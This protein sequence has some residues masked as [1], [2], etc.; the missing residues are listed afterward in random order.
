MASTSEARVHFFVLSL[1]YESDLCNQFD[2]TTSLFDLSFSLLAHVSCSHNDWDLRKS[3]LAENFA[4]A[5]WEE[6]E[7]WSGVLLVAGDV[8][9]SCLLWDESPKLVEVDGWLPEL[10][11]GLVE[12][13]QY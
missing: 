5:E 2:N 10:V 6:V 7:D 9:I 1:R 8:F 11:L 13:A 4:V 3:A 12:A